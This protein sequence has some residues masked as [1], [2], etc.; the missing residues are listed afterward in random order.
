MIFRQSDWTSLNT[1]TKLSNPDLL[2]VL[3]HD[4]HVARLYWAF[5]R[6]DPETRVALLQSTG[7]RNLLPYAGVMD[8]YGTQICIRSRRV[9]VPGGKAAESE[10][11]DLVGASPG[12]PGEFVMH[13]VAQDQGWL[14]VYFD[15]LARVG[16]T[17]QAHLTRGPRLRRLYEAFREPDPKH[18]RRR[19]SFRKAPALLILF[20]R[21]QWLPNG[22][23]R[24][25]GNLD[26]WKQ[27]LN[28]K[29]NSKLCATGASAPGI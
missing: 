7:L 9:L 25:P 16:Q 20:T 2:D 5:S 26:V 1:W 21:Q 12:S 15:T 22:E 19:A 11:K 17:Q 3:L 27:I 10:W 28:R 24:I 29:L 18:L 13:L 8:F 4:P 23:P 14:A 6:I